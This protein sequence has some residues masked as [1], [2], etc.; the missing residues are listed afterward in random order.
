MVLPLETPTWGISPTPPD[1]VDALGT[2]GGTITDSALSVLGAIGANSANNAFASN[3]VAAN[4]DGSVLER[5]EYL[6]SAVIT[7]RA[8][9]KA[10]GGVVNPTDALFTVA[11]GPIMITELVGQV[12]VEI[13]AGPVTCQL[14]AVP[15]APGNAVNLSTAVA[16]ETDA[17]GTTYTFTAVATPVLTPNTNGALPNAPAAKWL[18]PEGAIQ[19]AC[20]ANAAGNIRWHMVYKPLSP[21]STVVAAA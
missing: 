11:G 15:T 2:T 1:V 5:L 13:G 21:A 17:V 10:D 12:T 8:V 3:L 20:S 9:T 14:Q 6:Q 7:E 18:V 16:I 4:A 19:A